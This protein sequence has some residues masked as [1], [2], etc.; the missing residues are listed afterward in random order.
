MEF[1]METLILEIS[2]EANKLKMSTY[3]KGKGAEHRSY[4]DITISKEEIDGI[5]CDI[6]ELFNRANSQG[7]LTNS[8]SN[9]LRKNAQLLYDQLLT[10]DAKESI[11]QTKAIFL[12]F[13][14]DEQLVQYPWELLFDGNAFLCL[15]FAVGRVVRTKQKF[16][17]AQHRT[18]KRPL[19]MLALCDPTHNLNAAYN[20]GI[21]IRKVLDKKKNKIRLDLKTTDIDKRYVKRNI[22]DY[23]ILHYAGHAEYYLENPLKSGWILSDSIFTPED[24]STIG[25]SAALPSLI[26]SNTCQSGQTEEWKIEPGFEQK[27]Y[28]LANS[29]L[30]AGVRHYIGT[31]WKVSDNSCSLF[32]IE[33]YK[34]ISSGLAIGE[35]LRLARLRLV[36]EYGPSSIIW[37]SYMLYGDPSYNLL[38]PSGNVFVPKVKTNIVKKA[39][40][41]TCAFLILFS[42]YIATNSFI[43]FFK[44]D[45][46]NEGGI[47]SVIESSHSPTFSVLE[48]RNTSPENNKLYVTQLVMNNLREIASPN[49]VDLSVYLKEGESLSKIAEQLKVDRVITGDYRKEADNYFLNIRMIN[50]VDGKILETKTVSVADDASLGIDVSLIVLNMLKVGLTDEEKM[51]LLKKPT[52]SK[53]AYRLFAPT[54]DLFT[55]GRYTEALG[56][57]EQA[58][59]LDS[60]YVDVYKRMG[61]IYDRLKE[62]D[63]ALESYYKYA[64]L[65]RKN[66]DLFN[67]ANAYANIGWIMESKKDFEKSFEYY[68]KALEVSQQNN[69]KYAQAKSYSQIA[70]WHWKHGNKDKARDLLM[71]SIA[72]NKERSFEHNHLYNLAWNYNQMG[73]ML[74]VEKKYDKALDYFNRS[75]KIF[76]LLGDVRTTDEVTERI[77]NIMVM[78]TE[79]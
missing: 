66:S 25:G 62:K 72:L 26:F 39:I 16:Y 42:A 17:G 48:F 58:L 34:K 69:N 27:I 75:Q 14:I 64:E 78:K 28:G 59:E 8:Y 32:A 49:M 12:I 2:K 18:I 37:G 54:W 4:S 38:A 55:A 57:C 52:E 22:R 35:A 71:K 21:C 70:E 74:S 3:E 43:S 6:T 65:S 53:E 79:N 10:G 30:L 40:L 67:L 41:L 56:L 19:S 1:K 24:I 63:K 68:N 47:D 60:N 15:R 5:C 76:K 29:F 20:E 46:R 23:D 36:K 33:F 50:P 77:N 61:N 73:I 9:D 45:K 7:E 44:D 13:S 11:R 31:F 51:A